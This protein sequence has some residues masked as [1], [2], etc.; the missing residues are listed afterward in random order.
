VS[1]VVFSEPIDGRYGGAFPHG[2]EVAV[3]VLPDRHL[4]SFVCGHD[5][6]PV[7]HPVQIQVMDYAAGQAAARYGAIAPFE[8]IYPVQLLS[9]QGHWGLARIEYTSRDRPARC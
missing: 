5:A 9:A 6:V 8:L 2:A 1:D 4:V 7:V 3:S